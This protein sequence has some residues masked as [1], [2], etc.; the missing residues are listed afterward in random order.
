MVKEINDDTIKNTSDTTQISI[1]YYHLIYGDYIIKMKSKDYIKIK[2]DYHIDFIPS[3]IIIPC[4]KNN[5]IKD[6]EL[7][8]VLIWDGYPSDIDLHLL[9]KQDDFPEDI[10]HIWAGNKHDENVNML[11][12]YGINTGPQ[13]IKL[14]Y[15]NKEEYK[16]YSMQLSKHGKLIE[17]NAKLYIINKKGIYKII[18]INKKDDGLYWKICNFR[19]DNKIVLNE[20]NK[21]CDNV[22]FC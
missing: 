7:Y 15:E 6:N 17:S 2:I 12:D 18:N 14:K 11:L 22:Y 5:D 20:I 3:N 10:I 9:K 8:L 13:V 19:I 21:I 4:I 16:V 1:N